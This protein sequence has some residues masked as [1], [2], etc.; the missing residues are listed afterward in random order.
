MGSLALYTSTLLLHYM[1][2]LTSVSFS[3]LEI[4]VWEKLWS[5]E[6]DSSINH[7]CRGNLDNALE[8]NVLDEKGENEIQY[9][10]IGRW[11]KQHFHDTSKC[12]SRD[13]MSGFCVLIW[14]HLNV[15]LSE[16]FTYLVLS[17]FISLES[18]YLLLFQ[19]NMMAV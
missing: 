17:V 11:E 3:V 19:L 2:I 12:N 14:F 9:K 7:R 18:I 4:R 8:L 1:V 5:A 13:C 15:D 6:L 10:Y 16:F